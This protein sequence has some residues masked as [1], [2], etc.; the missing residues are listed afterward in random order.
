MKGNLFN[1]K[2]EEL[3]TSF[4]PMINK[5]LSSLSKKILSILQQQLNYLLKLWK[6]EI[7]SFD[8]QK[9]ETIFSDLWKHENYLLT[10]DNSNIMLVVVWMSLV[11]DD[12]SMTLD[13]KGQFQWYKLNTNLN[14]KMKGMDQTIQ[15]EFSHDKNNVGYP[16][17][18]CINHQQY[19][20]II[21]LLL[22]YVR[23]LDSTIN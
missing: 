8:L 4:E 1:W 14:G 19:N 3:A 21:I 6:K 23:N 7:I 2:Q 18:S 10:Y 12:T 16:A 5:L 13:N 11:S 15:G 9:Q 17:Y 20:E 22:H